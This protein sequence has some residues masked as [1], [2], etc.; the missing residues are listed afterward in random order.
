L[1][2]IL[3]PSLTSVVDIDVVRSDA[4]P[5]HADAMQIISFCMA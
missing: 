4:W 1:S 3:P 2:R 5:S